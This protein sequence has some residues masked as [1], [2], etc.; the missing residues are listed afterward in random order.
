MPVEF[1]WNLYP[2]GTG[3]YCFTD[4]D[5]NRHHADGWKSLVQKIVDYRS[6]NGFPAGDPW[7][8]ISAQH[9]ASTPDHCRDNSPRQV[10]VRNAPPGQAIPNFNQRV[11]EWLA[12][13]ISAKRVNS[14]ARVSDEEAARRAA[15]CVRCPRQKGLNEVCQACVMM[16]KTA[17]K[18]ILKG[19]ASRHQNLTPC[20]ALGEDC[21][22]SVYLAQPPTDQ[23]PDLPADCWRRPGK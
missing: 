3:G 10:Q 1:N 18:V 14:I 12:R 21:Q 22:V 19:G 9:C 15:I 2:G 4:R 17:R 6:R 8:E 13:M 20:G 11:S 5:G 23:P 7:V 16:A